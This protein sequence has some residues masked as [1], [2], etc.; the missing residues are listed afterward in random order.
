MEPVREYHKN[1]KGAPFKIGTKV[2]VIDSGDDTID[3]DYID[4]IGIIVYF[5][6]NTGCADTF[7]DNPMIGVKFE[8]GKEETFWKEE[9]DIVKK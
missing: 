3:R 2:T 8:D 7:P 9:L 5:R 1:V 4:K 6:Y